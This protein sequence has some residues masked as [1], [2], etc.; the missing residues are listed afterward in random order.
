MLCDPWK[1]SL[2]SWAG[3]AWLFSCA[4]I[5]FARQRLNWVSQYRWSNQNQEWTY[6]IHLF[7]KNLIIGGS[8][9]EG[10]LLCVC[11]LHRPH[12]CTKQCS[13]CLSGLKGSKLVPG[14]SQGIVV[15][16]EFG[17]SGTF[18]EKFWN[19][20]NLELAVIS[21]AVQIKT[22]DLRFPVHIQNISTEGKAQPL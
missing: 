15:F 9:I 20:H 1:R 11:S 18:L 14:L 7:S 22:S 21:A 17:A 10:K 19:P 16:L 4:Q 3:H 6:G 12:M 13:L 2:P 8:N 5:H